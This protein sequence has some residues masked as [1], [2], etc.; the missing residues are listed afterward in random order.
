MPQNFAEARKRFSDR[1]L[2]PREYLEQCLARIDE[3]EPVVR[4]FV[5]MNVDGARKA[6][7]ASSERYRG[8]K[9]LSSIDGMPV[10]IK[11]I[12]ET[13]DMQTGFGSPI[14]KD[15]RGGRDA[16]CV[17]ALRQ[18]GA[19]IVGKVVT[20]EFA[21]APPGPTTNPLD[22]TRT[23]GGS[24][25]GSAAA[26][27]A[28]ACDFALGSDTG[29]SVRAPAG[30]C[31]LV[32]LRP[33]HGRISLA[34][35]MDLSPSFDT[36]GWFSRDVATYA[37]VADVLLGRD[38]VPLPK[39]PRL[40]APSIAST[41]ARGARSASAASGASS[42]QTSLGASRRGDFGSGTGSRPSKT[43]ATRA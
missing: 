22:P 30:H 17:Y 37:R 14:F 6:A 33:S 10:A 9:P 28:N 40:L 2:S 38:P 26:V 35:V 19:V 11:D 15:W 27:A 43:S 31:G 18:A 42:A 1:V 41:S 32:G 13:E 4:A 16:A 36:C 7:D 3:R 23:P 5:S 8:G 25:S 20:T 29:G 24:S 34:N 21:G 39:S 12:I